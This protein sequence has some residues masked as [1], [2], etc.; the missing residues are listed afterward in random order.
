MTFEAT[1]S[2]LEM[3]QMVITAGMEVR[4]ETRWGQRGAGKEA[5]F[6]GAARWAG[7]TLPGS[8]TVARPP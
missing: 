5:V 1:V 8:G 7:A 4:M 2:V 3:D 6:V